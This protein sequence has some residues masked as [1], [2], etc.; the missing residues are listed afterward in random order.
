MCIPEPRYVETLKVTFFLNTVHL[1]A[2]K[3]TALCTATQLILMARAICK[4]RYCVTL[5]CGNKG[6]LKKRPQKLK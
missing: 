4:Q 5:K 2:F 3:I 1:K 6:N